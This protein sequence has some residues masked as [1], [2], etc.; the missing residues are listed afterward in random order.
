MRACCIVLLCVG[1]CA[2]DAATTVNLG[3]SARS[4]M[5]DI[6]EAVE[7][8]NQLTGQETF[9]LRLVDSDDRIDDQVILRVEGGLGRN[10]THDI[11]IG[12]TKRTPRGVIA[13]IVP[14]ATPCAI[15]HELGHA[16]G[17]KHVS[18][19]HNLMYPETGRDRWQLN[20][21]Q[22]DYLRATTF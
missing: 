7:R 16:A 6:T 14:M 9:S 10:A 21:E 19:E 8:L 12:N 11:R 17:L 5:D 4:K 1:A 3:P 18:D 15:A 22:L 13:R 2:D 20:A